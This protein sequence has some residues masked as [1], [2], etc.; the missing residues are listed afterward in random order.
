LQESQTT[1]REFVPPRKFVAQGGFVLCRRDW[2]N[3]FQKPFEA[4]AWNA[5]AWKT[6]EEHVRTVKGWNYVAEKRPGV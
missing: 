6:N 3:A 2:L 5:L 4:R 1:L